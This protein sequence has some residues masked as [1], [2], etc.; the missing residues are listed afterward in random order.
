MGLGVDT[1]PFL[2][3]TLE[4]SVEAAREG[5]RDGTVDTGA[6]ADTWSDGEKARGVGLEGSDA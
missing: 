3:Q 4:G 2:V 1:R 6:E 5:A